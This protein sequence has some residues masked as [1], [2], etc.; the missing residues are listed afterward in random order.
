[1]LSIKVG[2]VTYA[3]PADKV[4]H[5]DYIENITLL[6]FTAAPIEGL[7]HFNGQALLQIDV[8]AALGIAPHN[9]GGKRLLISDNQGNFALRVDEVVGFSKPKADKNQPVTPIL[10]LS[11][12]LP[13]CVICKPNTLLQRQNHP[14]V[15]NKAR[16][17]ITVLL[18]ASADKKLALFIHN[19]ELI[20]DITC[21]Q[22]HEEQ[23][24]HHTVL[25]KVKDQLLPTYSLS[26]L[27]GQN[28]AAQ[29]EAFAVVIRSETAPWALLVQQVIALET[30]TQF[31][32]SGIDS[33]GLEYVAQIEQIDKWLAQKKTDYSTAHLWYITAQ[34]QVQELVD[35]NQ[36]QGK[37]ITPLLLTIA[38]AQKL[39]SALQLANPLI[40]E[41]L[42][43]YCATGR[44]FLPL[45]MVTRTLKDFNRADMLT[46][47][48][49]G[50]QRV[51]RMP[52]I[53]AAAFL[54][55]ASE[56]PMD[57]TVLINLANKQQ[58]LLAVNRIALSQ[59]VTANE[60]WLP[61]ELPYPL[62]LFFDAGYYDS[63][64][65]QWILRVIHDIKF[66]NFPW[67]IKKSLLKAILGWIDCA[68][69]IE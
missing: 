65:Q 30:I 27:L 38:T 18:V 6:P 19:I 43:I 11:E 56:Q 32:S 10:P 16:Q 13:P 23:N 39:T 12:I 52:W 33:C 15:A 51:K 45:M 61:L 62:R 4:Q 50:S 26:R 68:A 9:S 14:P 54:F 2:D 48:G 8:A 41:G 31:Y 28:V 57:S 40:T 29:T 7:T 66:A 24:T 22:A 49:H 21:L 36:L 37:K 20:Q 55:G 59:M 1:M 3:I 44:Y 34:G 67:A 63:A 47:R 42:Q 60:K 17:K 64:S 46:S 5:V 58:I 35:A 53:N 25:I 69:V